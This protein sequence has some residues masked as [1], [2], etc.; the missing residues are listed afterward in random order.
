MKTYSKKLKI[1]IGEIVR[2]S[3]FN[4]KA[5][6]T[7][8]TR[9]KEVILNRFFMD[10]WKQRPDYDR[11]PWDKEFTPFT[12]ASGMI[13][14]FP[15]SIYIGGEFYGIDIFGLKKDKANFM[16]SDTD[17][18]TPATGLLVCGNGGPFD[19]ELGQ[20]VD[21]WQPNP[22]YWDEELN[23]EE[24]CTVDGHTPEDSAALTSFLTF[25]NSNDFTKENVPT[26][27]DVIGWMDYF[28]LMQVFIMFDNTSRNVVL[29]SDSNR[30]KFWPFFY[31]LDLA[32]YPADFD[33]T[34]ISIDADI[35]APGTSFCADMIV[36]DKLWDLYRDE[37]ITR[38]EYLRNNILSVD[39]IKKVYLDI[40]NNIPQSE[41]KKESDKWGTIINMNG[42][43]TNIEFLKNR[44]K[45]LD[46]NYFIK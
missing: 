22:E 35:L 46:E 14:G 21:S 44:L 32:W 12:S 43:Y 15:A 6:W 16:L 42:I 40:A 38:Y 33:R 27:M 2:L 17:G 34:N 25:V 31:D 11:L 26:R 20:F 10:I 29:Y 8:Y 5:N 23:D 19:S 36:W 9:I 39:Y 45:W 24:F 41:I 30:I 7:D 3:G 1:K 13:K 4:L 37:I 18:E 28:I